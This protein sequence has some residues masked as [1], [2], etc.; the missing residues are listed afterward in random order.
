LPVIRNFTKL[1]LFIYQPF[2]LIMIRNF[3]LSI[4]TLLLFAGTM[5]GQQRSCGANEVLARQLLENPDMKQI[6]DDIERHTQDFT[7]SGGVQDRVQVTIPVVV[8]VVYFNATQNISDA[9]ILSQI[10]VL[11]ADFRRLNADMPGAMRPG[12]RG[13]M[14]A[15]A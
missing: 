4:T 5:Y 10:D 13:A 2:S 6:M 1:E 12:Y 3:L 8:H 14:A 7:K 15:P 9:Q 11:N